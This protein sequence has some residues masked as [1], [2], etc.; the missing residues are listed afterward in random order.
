LKEQLVEVRSTIPVYQEKVKLLEEE[1]SLLQGQV[2]AAHVNAAIQQP[3]FN[4][5]LQEANQFKNR[6]RSSYS[7]IRNIKSILSLIEQSDPDKVSD[8]ILKFLSESEVAE[9]EIVEAFISTL[10]MKRKYRRH[11]HQAIVKKDL[12]E[13]SSHCKIEMY[14]ELRWKFRPWVCLMELDRVATVS[15]HGYDVIRKIEF[16]GEDAK[17]KRGLFYSRQKLT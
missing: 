15:L 8:I 2:T 1:N 10:C 4:Q 5:S 3:S 12:P 7:K 17:Y 14:T 6:L 11:L 16:Y 9:E 13:V